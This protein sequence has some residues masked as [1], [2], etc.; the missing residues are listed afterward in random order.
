MLFA[1]RARLG[2][3]D[4]RLEA[5]FRELARRRR[6]RRD[7]AAGSSASARRAAAGR[8]SSR[9]AWRRSRWKYCAAVVQFTSRRLMSAAACRNALGPR[10]RVL[11]PLALVA[12]RQQEDERRLQPPLRAAGGDELVEDHLRAVDEVAV[13]R[14]PDHQPLGLLDVVA[15]LEADGRVLG[16]RRCCGSRTTPAP[17]GTPAAARTACRCSRRGTPRGG[18]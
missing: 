13:L 5:P 9:C 8:A 7:A 6:H 18:G 12:V 10:A 17:A 4:D 3:V 15:E 1:R 2:V 11:G 16:Q 14:L